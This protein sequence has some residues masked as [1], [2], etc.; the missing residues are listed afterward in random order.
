MWSNAGLSMW[1][2]D[3][4][5]D[6]VTAEEAFSKSCK[7][8]SGGV[9]IA[10]STVTAWAQAHGYA[11]GANLT[12]VMDGMK[13]DGFQVNEQEKLDDGNYASVDWTNAS[14]L[15]APQNPKTPKPQNPINLVIVLY[16]IKL[17][18][19]SIINCN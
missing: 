4:D 13:T 12:D 3:V 6:C 10:E 9:L 19:H 16:I 11:N 17:N 5:G 8:P 15:Q 18:T 1:G 14:A 7:T 2:N